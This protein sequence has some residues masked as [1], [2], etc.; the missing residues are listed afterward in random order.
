[1]SFKEHVSTLLQVCSQRFYLLKLMKDQGTPL[2]IIHAISQSIIINRIAYCISAWGGFIP[3]FNVQKINSMFRRAKKYGYTHTVYD[4]Y[5]L[6][7]YH[8]NSLFKKMQSPKHCLNHILPDTI[9]AHWSMRKRA[10]PYC[11]PKTRT[12]LFRKSFLL[13][14]LYEH[15]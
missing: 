4:F 2:P 7:K 3:D 10:H 13:R 11:L 9:P 1:M 15:V 6:M 14:V 8:D 5:G 12:S